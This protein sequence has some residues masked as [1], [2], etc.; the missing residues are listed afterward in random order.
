MQVC[1]VE[2]NT[3]KLVRFGIV[4]WRD[5]MAMAKGIT[6][7]QKNQPPDQ[8]EHFLK[9]P[10]PVVGI[11]FFSEEDL[12]DSLLLV[13]EQTQFDIMQIPVSLFAYQPVL[14][15]L[16][17]INEVPFEEE[18]TQ[19]PT[20]LLPVRPKYLNAALENFIGLV[21]PKDGDNGPCDVVINSTPITLDNSQ[22]QALAQAFLN[23]VALIQ[24]PP[25]TGKTFIGSLILQMLHTNTNLKVLC[26]CYTNHALDQFLEFLIKAGIQDIVR[27]GGNSKNPALDPYQLRNKAQ[28]TSFNQSQKRRYFLLKTEVEGAER[29]IWDIVSNR[30]NP[31]AWG[32]VRKYL[33]ETQP[34]I[35][36]QL[37]F[38]TTSKGGM[39]MVG[40]GGKAILPQYLF[41]QWQNGKDPGTLHPLFFIY[42]F[43]VIFYIY[44]KDIC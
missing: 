33:E 7:R 40:K 39:K 13:G 37:N 26:V 17:R 36:K 43:I 16:K 20:T 25:G 5:E 18:F 21:Q 30:P 4:E 35:E 44:L 14:K 23:R 22:R 12:L 10:R 2:H 42:L 6:W 31:H 1:F 19:A 27:I 29:D 24:G 11:R 15:Q 28:R 9:A 38:T 3:R 41:N 8:H 32:V 34:E